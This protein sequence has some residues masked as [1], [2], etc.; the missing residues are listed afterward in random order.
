MKLQFKVSHLKKK[1]IY[2]DVIFFLSS[3]ENADVFLIDRF[4]VIKHNGIPSAFKKKKFRSSYRLNPLPTVLLLVVGTVITRH[5]DADEKKIIV[6]G[7][8]LCVCCSHFI[9]FY[10]FF[11][12]LTFAWW[13]RLM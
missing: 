12:L 7:T 3:K 8:Q 10:F 11:L 5:L 13:M 1:E 6:I 9:L 4:D 2:T